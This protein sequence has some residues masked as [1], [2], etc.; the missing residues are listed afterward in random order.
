MKCDPT[1]LAALRTRPSI[2]FELSRHDEAI[3]ACEEF[4]KDQPNDR[5]VRID[6]AMMLLKLKRAKE[7]IKHFQYF[8]ENI[9]SDYPW[10]YFDM[11]CAHVILDDMEGFEKNML[12]AIEYGFD[13]KKEMEESPYLSSIRSTKIYLDILN[14]L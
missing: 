2:L 7:S 14:R 11:A 13:S 4:L 9:Q 5:F 6:L 12:K 8:C 10:A 1:Y 3:K